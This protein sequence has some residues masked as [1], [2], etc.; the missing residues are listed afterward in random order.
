MMPSKPSLANEFK[1]LIAAPTLPDVGPGPRPD[2]L[3]ADELG[4][5][6]DRFFAAR[7]IV[8]PLRPW[9]S[10]AALIWHDHLEASHRL[11]QQISGPDGSFLH[12]IVHRREPDPGNAAH[13]FHRVGRHEAYRE[14]A[15]QA[16]R[17]LVRERQH[18]LLARLAPNGLWDPFA[19]I[20]ACAAAAGGARNDPR[21]ALLGRVQEW[22]F[23]ALVQHVLGRMPAV[24]QIAS[25]HF[26]PVFHS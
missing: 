19:F 10:S 5:R 14:I 20:D 6:L 11:S 26:P 1:A 24:Q 18:E 7:A 16:T 12:G 21:R 23:D 17:R 13:W 2:R 9:L 8:D 25:A 4:A 3:P 15:R 22:E